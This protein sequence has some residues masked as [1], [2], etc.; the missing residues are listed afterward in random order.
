MK[1]LLI[2]ISIVLGSSFQLAASN[3][4]NSQSLD[5]LKNEKSVILD[6]SG[7]E[8]KVERFTITDHAGE[9]IFS[10]KVNDCEKRV[11]YDLS[12]LPSGKYDIKVE[13]ENFVELHTTVITDEQVVFESVESHFCP[14]FQEVDDMIMVKAMLLNEENIR[15]KIYNAEGVLVYE[16]KDQKSGDFQKTFDLSQLEKGEYDI[17]VSTDYFSRSSTV[18]L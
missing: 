10:T 6:L 2:A 4:Y 5:A 11:K 3:V 17:I 14:N 16:Y 15:M 8:A 1:N 13:G 18:S 7:I 9:E 12:K